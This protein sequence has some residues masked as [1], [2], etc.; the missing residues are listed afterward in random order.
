MENLGGVETGHY[1]RKGHV[2]DDASQIGKA[3]RSGTFEKCVRLFT[4]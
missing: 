4:F 3:G 2:T 1:S